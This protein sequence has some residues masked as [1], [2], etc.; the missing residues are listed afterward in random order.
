AIVNK[1]LVRELILLRMVA[2]RN[3]VAFLRLDS[4]SPIGNVHCAACLFKIPDIEDAPRMADCRMKFAK[5]QLVHAKRLARTD[6]PSEIRLPA[7][8][9]CRGP[10]AACRPD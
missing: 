2:R 5:A 9:R 7:P 3:Q 6:R 4:W 1:G 10:R 8:R